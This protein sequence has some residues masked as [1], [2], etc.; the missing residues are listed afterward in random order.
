MPKIKKIYV[1]TNRV[2]P[3]TRILTLDDI[4]NQ[5][6]FNAGWTGN[7][8][9]ASWT[10]PVNYGYGSSIRYWSWITKNSF[11]FPVKWELYI[12]G[13]FWPHNYDGE[14]FWWITDT[15]YS[16]EFW[17]G[18]SSL[19]A[20]T[21]NPR[22]SYWPTAW[23]ANTVQPTAVNFLNNNRY[24]FKATWDNGVVNAWVND[25]QVATNKS[26]TTPT[27]FNFAIWGGRVSNSWAVNTKSIYNFYIKDLT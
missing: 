25:T 10:N 3:D 9:T 18:Q 20:S 4:S 5:S 7:L 17:F 11:T 22:F 21:S 8:L 15:N 2:R 19:T 1:G 13:I 12:D 27:T 6:D 26:F 14:S 23:G 24:T 16:Y